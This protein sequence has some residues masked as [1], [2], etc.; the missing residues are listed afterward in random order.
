MIFKSKSCFS[1]VMDYP[2]LAVVGEVSLDGAMLPRF[3]LVT[4][5]LLFS[6]W[7]SPVLVGPAVSG[8]SLSLLRACKPVSPPLA[9]QL[10]PGTKG[11]G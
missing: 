11:C 1:I 5:H 3:L 8:W 2:G 7:L 10:S 4:L 6:I 9:D